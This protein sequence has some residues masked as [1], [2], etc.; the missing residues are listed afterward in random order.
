MRFPEFSGEWEKCKIGDFGT[1]ITGNTPPTSNMEFYKN[2]TY[3]WATPSD[4]GHNKSIVETQ[5]KLTSK[6]FEKTRKLPSDS[7][8]VTCIGSTIGKMGMSKEQMSTNQ[9]INA[10]VPEKHDSNF[11]YY[12][13][14]SRFPKYL[15]SIAVQA[16]PMLSKS[17]FEKLDNNTTSIEE[18]TKIGRFLSL[19]D[20]RIA[21]QIK[22]IEKLES[23]IRG[24]CQKLTQQGVPNVA[25][26]ECLEC[27]T[28]TL[29]ESSVNE[30]GQYPVY[31][32]NGIC[33]YT[34]MP[35]VNDDSILII[36]DGASVGTTYYVSGEYSNIGTLSRLIAKQGYSLKY[37]YYTL[38]VFNFDIYRTGLAIPH[39]YFKDY[40][41]AKIW[42]PSLDKQKH[43]ADMLSKVDQK[44][45]IEKSLLERLY[46]QKRYLLNAM[47][48]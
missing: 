20:E 38:K 41:K 14:Q 21:T 45:T 12:A 32:A 8:L 16:V 3:L 7:V 35:E 31:G 18:Q 29:L 27:R 24:L 43:I 4:L 33:G 46:S 1:I 28:S 15:S 34:C 13:V 44:I 17:S 36:K 22:A 5:T 37:I 23:L 19:I 40:G 30:V 9:Q 10:I 6:G 48:I 26:N 47:F 39:I 42:S 11:V 2:G 25:L